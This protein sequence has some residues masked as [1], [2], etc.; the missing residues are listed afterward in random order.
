M[1]LSISTSTT[2]TRSSDP[3]SAREFSA[4]SMPSLCRVLSHTNRM[5][6]PFRSRPPSSPSAAPSSDPR[7]RR[8]LLPC[9]APAPTQSNKSS[10]PRPLENHWAKSLVPHSSSLALIRRPVPAPMT[11]STERRRARTRRGALVLR[12]ETIRRES[13]GERR[14]SRHLTRTIPI[15]APLSTRLPIGCLALLSAEV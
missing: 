12:V 8:Q 10:A 4:K 6:K 2:V 13:R 15:I 14:I 7:R 9:Q 5:R 1:I 3:A 11:A